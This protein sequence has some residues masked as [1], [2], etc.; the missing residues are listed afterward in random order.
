[1]VK[2]TT[3][4]LQEIEK[5]KV[6]RE[7]LKRI[8]QQRR[9]LLNEEMRKPQKRKIEIIEYEDGTYSLRGYAYDLPLKVD[10][11]EFAFHSWLNKLLEK[12]V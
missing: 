4:I 5:N 3:K 9:K 12:R 8:R 7:K 2:T 10:E 6:K 1:M 11:V